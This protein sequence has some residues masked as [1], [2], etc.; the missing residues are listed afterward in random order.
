MILFLKFVYFSYTNS[1]LE[2]EFVEDVSKAEGYMMVGL[3]PESTA[4]E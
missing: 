4:A 2:R 1:N 3:C